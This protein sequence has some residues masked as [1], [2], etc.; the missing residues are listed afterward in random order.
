MPQP[1]AYLSF[2]G[3]CEDAMRFYERALDGKLEKLI[4]NADSPWADQT[5]PEERQRIMHAR[6]ILDGNGV[7]YAGD[8]PPAMPYEGIKGVT[9]ALNYDTVEQAQRVFDRLSEGGNVHMPMRPVFWAKSWG[10][11]VDRFGTP[12][13]VNGEPLP[14]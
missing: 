10:M 6:L 12:W 7:L 3:N 13:M 4:R 2:N 11:L 5:P 14:V 9:L 1:I 8:C